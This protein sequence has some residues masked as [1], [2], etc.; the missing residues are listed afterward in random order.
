MSGA[1][2][3]GAKPCPRGSLLFLP[4]FRRAELVCLSCS[5]CFLF[6]AVSDLYLIFL[7]LSLSFSSAFGLRLGIWV[8]VCPRSGRRAR[9]GS[10]HGRPAPAARYLYP[11]DK[12]GVVVEEAASWTGPRAPLRY[13]P[14]FES[15]AKALFFL[16]QAR[17]PT[18]R[19]NPNRSNP[20]RSRVR[21]DRT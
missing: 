7:S 4:C 18:N 8:F 3:R 5:F 13:N 1:Q 15:L 17:R 12:K 21:V 20:H 10:A 2:A 9:S 19:T 11:T 6:L 16:A 14:A